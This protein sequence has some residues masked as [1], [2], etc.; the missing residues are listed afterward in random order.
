MPRLSIDLEARL[1]GFQDSLDKATKIA[2]R[3]ADQME[4]AFSDVGK[5]IR[6]T[7]AGLF[8]GIGIAALMRTF[9]AETVK[10]Q[11]AQAQLA[12]VVKSTGQAAGYSVEQLNKMAEELSK[13]S[14]F[15]GDD[16]REA[17]ARLLSY[18][19][20]VGEQFPRAMR[21][22][23]DMAARMGTSV[24][25]S[26]E[27]VGRALDIPSQGLTS[28]Q[29]QG[30]RFTE[31]QKKAVEQL[32]KTGKTAQAQSIVLD[33][34]ESSYGGAASAAR[35]TFG[36]ALAALQNQV[37]G[38]MAGE[39]GSLEGA[40]SAIERL[41][42]TMGSPATKEAFETLTTAF[43]NLVG[44][45]AKAIAATV[46][47]TAKFGD[48]IGRALHGPAD[49]VEFLGEKIK[50]LNTELQSVEK[51]LA[52]TNSDSPAFKSLLEQAD[53]LRAKIQ[54][55]Q[56]A[57]GTRR[58][59]ASPDFWAPT[60]TQTKPATPPLTAA[61]I[62]ALAAQR[63][64]EEARKKAAEAAVK[65]ADSYIESLR[66]QLQNAQELTV[67][68]KTLEEIRSGAIR[69]GGKERQQAAL[70]YAASIDA[71][72]EATK[73]AKETEEEFQR[74]MRDSVERDNER[75]RLF[76]ETRTPVEH[77]ANELD[78]LN[79]MLNSGLDWDTYARAVFNAHEKFDE[80]S[81]K[82]KEVDEFALQA[83]RNIQDTLGDSLFDVLDGKFENIGKSF[84]DMI[85][86]MIAEAAAADL[87]KWLLGD[88]V[89]GG[90]GGG[91]LGGLFSGILSLFSPN[92]TG[93]VYPASSLSAYSN[94]V[95]NT[96]QVFA[97]AKGGVGVF[98][99]AGEEAIMPL[100]R[101]RDGKLGV[102]SYGGGQSVIVQQSITFASNVDRAQ[103]AAYA[104]RIKQSTIASIRQANLSG[105]YALTG[106]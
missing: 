26:A 89:K 21:A 55:L 31:E 58:A 43:A 91:S 52:R 79:K 71:I 10:A 39:G 66:K 70:A 93:N 73:R 22:V 86:R 92:A 30:F 44:W 101:G 29:K 35:D 37:R 80:A 3:Q 78:R 90:K 94:G 28:L 59:M 57:Q 23:I 56:Q 77:L 42:E 20:V 32:E 105:N 46:E 65:Q 75:K 104:E 12:A 38:L 84:G 61:E 88:M 36:G 24:A 68:E 85:K 72:S 33:A 5:S 64:A 16:I 48:M 15:D 53:K 67:V 14:T 99:E 41:T 4:R 83:A 51:N 8:T 98:A 9:T 25:Q 49:S 74:V 100:K 60:Q 76:E 34:L 40:R 102:S 69:G 45:T 17:Q 50:E 82:V 62:A 1:A 19:G 81:K 6:S 18:T 97:F 106:G 95:Y 11:N 103:M 54:S 47:F 7:F 63:E 96:P 13:S 87:A 2:K 27:T